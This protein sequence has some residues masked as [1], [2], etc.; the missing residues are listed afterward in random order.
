M[1][2]CWQRSPYHIL[3]NAHFERHLGPDFA[4]HL[5]FISPLL[6]GPLSVALSILILQ[7]TIPFSFWRAWKI[8]KYLTLPAQGGVE[9]SAKITK[10]I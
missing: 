1:S 4:V 3:P 9:V 2:H 5:H 6:S 10:P 8:I 7:V